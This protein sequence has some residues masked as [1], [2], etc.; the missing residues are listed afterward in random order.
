MFHDN[1]LIHCCAD[2]FDCEFSLQSCQKLCHSL[3][4]VLA[5]IEEHKES[6]LAD[7]EYRTTPR[8]KMEDRDKPIHFEVPANFYDDPMPLDKPLYQVPPFSV[9]CSKFVA[10]EHSHSPGLCIHK[11]HIGLQILSRMDSV[12]YTANTEC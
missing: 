10:G 6:C 11:G 7:D 4:M 2:N 1:S 5:Q 3:A 9:L 8:R 12:P